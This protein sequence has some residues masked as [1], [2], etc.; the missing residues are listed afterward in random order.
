MFKQQDQN[1]KDFQKNLHTAGFVSLFLVVKARYL[2]TS[3]SPESYPPQTV[4]VPPQA[5]WARGTPQ[6]LEKIKAAEK[7]IDF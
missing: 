3:F 2:I 7:A 1:R 5:K 6:P 4:A